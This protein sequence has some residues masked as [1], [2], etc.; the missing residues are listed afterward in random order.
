MSNC[1]WLYR[2]AVFR[3]PI[4]KYISG[5]NR[6]QGFRLL[7]AYYICGSDTPLRKVWRAPRGIVRVAR[8][9]VDN[10]LRQ[11]ALRPIARTSAKF[12]AQ[13]AGSNLHPHAAT[14]EPLYHVVF[15]VYPGQ[16]LGMSKYRYIIGDN[17]VKK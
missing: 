6:N 9:N 14:S 10:S 15:G 7:L 16:S 17:N 2:N 8:E 1:D 5:S 4:G 13:R 11:H 12:A 3:R